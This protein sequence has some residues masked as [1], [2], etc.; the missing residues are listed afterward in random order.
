MASRAADRSVGPRRAFGHSRRRRGGRVA[1]PRLL[2][3]VFA[4][5]QQVLALDLLHDGR[6]LLVLA[7][8]ILVVAQLQV[9]IAEH[10]AADDRRGFFLPEAILG[11]AGSA[12]FG[13]LLEAP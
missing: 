11:M 12:P 7:I 8:T 1:W 13:P 9:L 2:G 4:Q 3:K 6:H 10:L 5:C